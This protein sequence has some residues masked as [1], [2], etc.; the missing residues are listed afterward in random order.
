MLADL[1]RFDDAALRELALTHAS[2]GAEENNERL[3]FLGDAVLDVLVAEELFHAEPP[4][5][6]GEMTEHKAWVVSR[7][8]LATAARELHLGDHA[9]LGAGMRDRQ[10]PRSVLANLYE[11]YLGAI[12]LDAGLDAARAFAQR[13]LAEPLRRVKVR[14]LGDAHNPKQ[15]LQRRAQL[16]TGEPPSY[17]LVEERGHAHAKAFLVA[18]E[19]GGRSFPCA[20][21]RTR[22]EAERWAAYEALLVLDEESQE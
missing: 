5:S 21:G 15:E 8:A 22:K 11:A 14:E 6:E 13:T 19:C 20:W 2:T 18:A 16:E 12:Y 10:L 7:E 9:R 3:E 4:Q 17:A 1:H